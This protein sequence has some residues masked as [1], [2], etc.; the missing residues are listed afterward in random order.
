MKLTILKDHVSKDVYKKIEQAPPDG[1][2]ALMGKK[3][4]VYAAIDKAVKTLQLTK[5]QGEDLRQ[6]EMLA[7]KI[8]EVSYF[9]DAKPMSKEYAAEAPKLKI[10][11]VKG[12]FHP[13]IKLAKNGK[14]INELVAKWRKNKTKRDFDK[15]ASD[16]VTPKDAKT[17][18][19]INVTYLDKQGREKYLT[20]FKKGVMSNEALG[21]KA[22]GKFIYVLS[23]DK[24]LFVAEKNRGTFNHSTF[25]AGKPVLCAGK[26]DV[27][28]GVIKRVDKSSGHYKTT[29]EMFEN[30]IKFLSDKKHLGKDEA[31]KVTKAA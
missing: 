30:M 24:E 2:V 17:L 20:A 25:F 8:K 12:H 27:E 10:A 19:E 13:G 11:G 22:T 3:P 6:V 7:A 31:R 16:R 15:W 9:T 14:T 26:M 4:K 5:L 1:L 28:E 21:K 18:A 29:D 23:T